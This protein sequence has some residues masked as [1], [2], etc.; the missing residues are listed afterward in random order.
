M[1]GKSAFDSVLPAVVAVHDP[2][3]TLTDNVVAGSERLG[4]LMAGPPCTAGWGGVR[5]LHARN[6]AHSTL[7][8]MRLTASGASVQ[9]DCTLLTAFTSYLHVRT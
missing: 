8:G 2:N 9:D 7:A 3:I 1:S 4:W 5:A 6:S